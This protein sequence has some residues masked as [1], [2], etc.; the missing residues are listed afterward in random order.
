MALEEDGASA[1]A[2]P[3]ATQSKNCGAPEPA[4]LPGAVLAA[5]ETSVPRPEA[6]AS[7]PGTSSVLVESV[8]RPAAA[9]AAELRDTRVKD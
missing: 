1:A 2:L 3:D 7:G 5:A 9:L 4:A 6:V 8:P